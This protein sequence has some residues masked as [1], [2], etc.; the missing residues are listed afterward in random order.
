MGC[1][2]PVA[3]IID[4]NPGVRKFYSYE[5]N[6][7]GY[8]VLCAEN[9]SVAE[10]LIAS[11]IPDIILLDP[12]IDGEFRWN[13]LSNIKKRNARIPVLLCM[14]LERPAPE[15]LALADGFIVKSAL[16]GGLV[17]KMEEILKLKRKESVA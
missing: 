5:L 12:W 1:H 17:Q 14:T 16:I 13:I 8:R 4:E 9:A 2:S 3:M 11:I 7:M 6:D 15:H 10:K